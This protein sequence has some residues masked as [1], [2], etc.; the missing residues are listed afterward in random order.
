MREREI[1]LVNEREKRV[2]EEF[3]SRR[4][5]FFSSFVLPLLRFL[6]TTFEKTHTSKARGREKV[7]SYYWYIVT[8]NSPQDTSKN[9]RREGNNPTSYDAINTN[10][11]FDCVYRVSIEHAPLLREDGVDFEQQKN[12][13]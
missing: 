8:I 12:V 11:R 9:Q 4:P 6:C 2:T 5:F 13:C 3:F 10:N 7:E 1:N